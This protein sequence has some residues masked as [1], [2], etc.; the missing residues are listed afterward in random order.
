MDDH[1]ILLSAKEI[2]QKWYNV[3]ADL[4]EPIPPH[5]HPGTGKPLTPDDLR[6]L[7]PMGLIMQEVSTERWIEIPDPI[8][9]KLALWRPSPLIRAKYL[10]KA[11]KT[12]ARIYYKYEGVSPSG[13]HKPNTAV[14]QAYY[15]KIEG[16]KRIATETGAGQWGCSLAFACDLFGLECKVY[17]VKC[18]YDQKPYRRSLMRLW[19]GTVVASPSMDTQCGRKILAADPNCSGSLGIAISEAVEDAARLAKTPTT[20]S[21]RSSTTSACTSPSSGSKSRNSSPSPAKNPM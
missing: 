12:P 19:G 3:A 4:P 20:P 17:M 14:A 5:L 15:N 9:E 21:A 16:I 13:S 18:S 6:P 1:R 8:R 10:E 7:F 2:P 11:L